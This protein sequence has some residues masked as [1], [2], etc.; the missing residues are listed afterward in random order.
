MRKKRSDRLAGVSSAVCRRTLKSIPGK[1]HSLPRAPMGLFFCGGSIISDHW[2]LTAAHCL[3]TAGKLAKVQVKEG[4]TNYK[5]E[6]AWVRAARV[7]P[8]AAYN[9]ATEENDI[10][11]VKVN[12]EQDKQAVIA[13]ASI[14][15]LLQ[16]GT[17]LEITGWG[18]TAEGGAVVDSLRMADV[19]YVDTDSCNAPDAY[20]GTIKAGMICAGF[21]KGGVDTCQGDSGGPLVLKSARI[22][23]GVTSFGHGC[24]RANKYGIYTRVSFYR[25]WMSRILASD[26]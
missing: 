18:A 12:S 1:S 26:Q 23:V 16:V 15:T 2:I 11:L 25:D 14:S 5:S 20:N 22:L 7:E 3:G 10:A 17:P 8:H 19:N 9:S 21:Q 13:L 24:A 6:G 4:V